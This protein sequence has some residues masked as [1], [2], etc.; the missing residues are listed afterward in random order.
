MCLPARL[1]LINGTSTEYIRDNVKY[2][3]YPFPVRE[4]LWFGGLRSPDPSVVQSVASSTEAASI[5]DDTRQEVLMRPESWLAR[6]SEVM[7][8]LT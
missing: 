3:D 2:S 6:C 8:R 7:I 5:L 4:V 1:V